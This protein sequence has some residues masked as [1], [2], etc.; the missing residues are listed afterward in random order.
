MIVFTFTGGWYKEVLFNYIECED[1]EKIS[2]LLK[3]KYNTEI[4]PDKQKFEDKVS[5]WL[6]Y[7]DD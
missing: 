2:E 3:D 6:L 4:K 1:W 7:C 5:K